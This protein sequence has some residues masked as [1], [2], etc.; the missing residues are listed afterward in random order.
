MHYIC[1]FLKL[2]N[3]FKS[4]NIL[5]VCKYTRSNWWYVHMIVST[6]HINT[7]KNTTHCLTQMIQKPSDKGISMDL[8]FLQKLLQSLVEQ[9]ISIH[10]TNKSLDSKKKDKIH[11]CLVL[12]MSYIVSTRL[13]GTSPDPNWRKENHRLK[14]ALYVGSLEGI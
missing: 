8:R 1:L 13:V 3:D 12:V 7:T 10:R 2:N 11:S 5:P 4:C 14:N 9:A 6:F